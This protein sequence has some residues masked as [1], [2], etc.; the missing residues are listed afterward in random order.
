M[1]R[2]KRSGTGGFAVTKP[3]Q[4][5]VDVDSKTET[6]TVCGRQWGLTDWSEDQCYAPSPAKTYAKDVYLTWFV[7]LGIL[8]AHRFY[9]GG[10][11]GGVVT[12]FPTLMALFVS[13]ANETPL[14][15]VLTG[16][17]MTVGL[18]PLTSDKD[19]WW[20]IQ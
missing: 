13:P 11:V 12:A 16:I 17:A 6:C 7:F 9:V 1:P 14:W 8:G 5:R 19:R 2:W 4:I 15:W 3:C 10:W 20:E 18:V